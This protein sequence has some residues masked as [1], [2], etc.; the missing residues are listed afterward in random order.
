MGLAIQDAVA[1]LDDGEADRLRQVALARGGPHTRTDSWRAMNSQVA[2]SEI[3]ALLSL[4]IEAAAEALEGLR[5]VEGG[6]AKAQAELALGAPFDFVLQQG[7][8][9]VDE[10]RL[11]LDCRLRTSRVWRIPDRR[12][13]RSMGVS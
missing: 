1:L 13:V 4:G 11:L 2:R 9:E 12:R 5:G 3:W 6:V 10:G 8:E 7:G